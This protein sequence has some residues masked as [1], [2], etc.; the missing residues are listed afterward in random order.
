MMCETIF[1]I[2]STYHDCCT[3]GTQQNSEK[4]HFYQNLRLLMCVVCH[5]CYTQNMFMRQLYIVLLKY[6]TLVDVT[7]Y[8]RH[9][10][11]LHG[12]GKHRFFFEN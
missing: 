1:E 7:T 3:T 10:Q 6:P 4:Q 12:F 5:M 8:I 11:K 9:I 2:F